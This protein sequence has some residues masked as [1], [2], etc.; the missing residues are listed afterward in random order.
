MRLI[1]MIS[2]VLSGCLLVS[3]KSEKARNYSDRIVKKENA[4]GA[5][6]ERATARLRIYFANYDYDSIVGISGRMEQKIAAVMQDIQNIPPPRLKEAENFKQETLKYLTYKK[7]IFTTY[8]DYGLQTTPQGRE[9]LR[10]NMAIVLSQ[11]N[12]M[13]YNL[14]AAQINFARANHVKLK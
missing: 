3:C 13:N 4:L 1:V 6:I 11:E 10:E 12:A 14:H 7:N 9:M 2:I 8:K 5:D